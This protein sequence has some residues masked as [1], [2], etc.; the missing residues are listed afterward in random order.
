LARDGYEQT[1]D[2]P[3]QLPLH[4]SCQVQ[5]TFTPTA[6][7]PVT[8]FLVIPSSDIQGPNTITLT[9]SGK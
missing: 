7:G 4:G 9:G 1:N 5:V 8:G 6:N 3:S 2:C